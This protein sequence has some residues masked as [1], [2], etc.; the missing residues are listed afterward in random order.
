MDHLTRRGSAMSK[1]WMWVGLCAVIGLIILLAGLA[2][3]QDQNMNTGTSTNSNMNA[4][5]KH[6]K[7]DNTNSN[8]SANMNT[9]GSMNRNTNTTG[10]LGSSDRK[11]VMEAGMGGM[12]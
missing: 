1:G 4:N 10:G 2:P 11:F 6:K 12:E 8:M 3:A 9:S 7:H 5:T